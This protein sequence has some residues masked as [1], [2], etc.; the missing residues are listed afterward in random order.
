MTSTVNELTRSFLG[1]E[2]YEWLATR[3]D[4]IAL[5]LLIAL[6]IEREVVREYLG[7]GARGRIRAFSVA[8]VALLPVFAVVAVVRTLR[9]R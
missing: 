5:G 9:L 8:I 2:R 7:T 1:A 6:L 4:V 3:A